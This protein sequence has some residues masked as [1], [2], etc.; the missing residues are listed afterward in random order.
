M[1]EAAYSSTLWHQTSLTVNVIDFSILNMDPTQLLLIVFL[2][3]RP[4]FHFENVGISKPTESKLI[5]FTVLLSRG[6]QMTKCH[7]VHIV[8]CD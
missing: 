5:A 8:H 6:Q 3:V 1:R 4:L 7:N 2:A